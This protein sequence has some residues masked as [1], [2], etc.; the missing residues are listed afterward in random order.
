MCRLKIFSSNWKNTTFV[1]KESKI[2]YL[3]RPGFRIQCYAT[4]FIDFIDFAAISNRQSKIFLSLSLSLTTWLWDGWHLR[5]W[6][7]LLP[8]VGDVFFTL[9]FVCE[10]ALWLFH[11]TLSQTSFFV[12]FFF[13]CLVPLLWW[14]PFFFLS[15]T[16]LF[17]A[18]Y[19]LKVF[20]L[21]F[22]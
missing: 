19:F 21:Y 4:P 17:N 9:H 3:P 15:L 14:R 10:L 11:S 20:H 22:F 1:K 7:D 12:C 13:I 18:L 5:D 2:L 16:S 8:P 6:D